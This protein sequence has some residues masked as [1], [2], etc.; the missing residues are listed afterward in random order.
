MAE[1]A[2]TLSIE[3]LKALVN[4]LDVLA[5]TDETAKRLL[6]MTKSMS[7][8][9]EEARDQGTFKNATSCTR[10]NVEKLCD[11]IKGLQ[12]WI[13]EYNN[14][15]KTKGKLR[16]LRDYFYAG[17]NLNTLKALSKELDQAFKSLNLSLNL[18]VCAGVKD[19]VQQQFFLAKEVVGIIQQHSGSPDDWQLAETIAKK[20]NIAF[21]NVKQELASNMDYLKKVDANVALIKDQLEAIYNLLEAKLNLG[22][23]VGMPDDIA[24]LLEMAPF[25]KSE[26]VKEKNGM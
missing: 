13:D 4:R 23:E 15:G 25:S 19:L 10:Q 26:W 3:L 8:T 17:N 21:E 9:L 14:A 5:T 7:Y 2:A 20:T 22:P 18:E 11:A 1:T 16:R 24:N 12:S 6:Q